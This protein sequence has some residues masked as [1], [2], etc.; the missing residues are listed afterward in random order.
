RPR[1]PLHF[2]Y[3]TLFRSRALS[4][5]DVTCAIAAE[6][7]SLSLLVCSLTNIGPTAGSNG[8]LLNRCALLLVVTNMVALKSERRVAPGFCL[9]DRKSTRL[10]SSHVKIS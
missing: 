9:G 4:I 7:T 1:L 3:T 8:S 6:V 5:V 2:P 10:N